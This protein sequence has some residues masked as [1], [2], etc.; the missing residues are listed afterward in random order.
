MNSVLSAKKQS[1]PELNTCNCCKGLDVKAP[2]LINNRPGLY[3]LNYRI[4]THSQFK[5]S[6]LARISCSRDSRLQAAL[7]QLK[8]REDNDFSIALLDAWAV[9]ADVLTFYQERIANESYLLTARERFS[10]LHLARL[11]GYE[12]RP[13]S[14]ASTYL[15]FTMEEPKVFGNQ[16]VPGI[17]ESITLEPG[18]KVQSVPG[19]GES[20][21]T[22][23]TIEKI[24]CRGKWNNIRPRLTKKQQLTSTT[25]TVFLDGIG[26]NLKLG[27]GVLFRADSGTAKGSYV[28]GLVA[29]LEIKAEQNYTEVLLKLKKVESKILGLQD[30]DL[31]GIKAKQNT[32][33]PLVT[34]LL[35]RTIS[36]SELEAEAA[37]EKFKVQETFDNL[38]ASP[39]SSPKVL[40]FRTRAMVF[41]HNAPSWDTL[42]VTLRGD[43]PVYYTTKDGIVYIKDTNP[44][45]YKGREDSWSDANLWEY[46][47]PPEKAEKIVSLKPYNGSAN[48][49]LVNTSSAEKLVNLKPSGK[50]FQIKKIFIKPLYLYNTLY[51]D[52]IYTGVVQGSYVILK[53]EDTWGIYKVEDLTELSV[54]DFTFSTKV[55][56]LT[57][58]NSENYFPKFSIRTT[59][60]FGQ[61]EE[62]SLSRVPEEESFPGEGDFQNGNEC[63]KLEGWINGLY[64]GQHIVVSG[65][66]YGSSGIKAFE[67]AIIDKVEHVLAQDGCTQISLK[68]KL[69]NKYVRSTV[70]INGNVALATHGETREEVLGSGSAQPYQHF[71]LKQPPLTYLTADTPS[72][73][74]ST[75]EVRVNDVLWHEKPKLYGHGPEERIYETHL[76]NEGKT[77]IQFGDGKTGSLLPTG[78]EN[79]RATYR[80]G[81]GLEGLLKANQLSLLMTR[82][83]G[84]SSVT[85]PF[86]SGGGG[87][88]DSEKED[89][90]RQNAPLTVL[91]LDRIVSL[92]DYED[93]ARSFTGISKT[94][95][96][97]AWEGHRRK[98]FITVAGPNGAEIKSDSPIID[99][100]KSAISKAGDPQTPVKVESYKKV[101]FKIAAHINVV[102]DY[103]PDKVL[104]I[105]TDTLRDTFSFSRRSFGQPV[106]LSEVTATIQNVTGVHSVNVLNLYRSDSSSCNPLMTVP[107]SALEASMPIKGS[108]AV[109]AELLILDPGPLTELEVE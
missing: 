75:L 100:L 39:E 63:L 76:D 68:Q 89:E 60:V 21:Q 90:G 4:G 36:S 87:A 86:D 72:G 19:P 82:P 6:M 44:G 10:L 93:F 12:L 5:Q 48:L 26:T 85:N 62:L 49:R 31:Q 27:D 54:S 98:I 96:T 102:P 77:T 35:G 14:A 17:P 55:T 32:L 71:T 107:P 91:T 8:T 16:V 18:I 33:S 66:I 104:R 64:S 67:H 105:V 59:T 74:E 46:N 34:G 53:S 92:K 52:N 20:V 24:E 47:Y 50:D 95:A 70:S 99:K 25:D 30:L 97:W 28:F 94:L 84:L 83:L 23:E 81:L 108:G 38:V 9:I 65:E 88:A 103:T 3:A 58:T 43:E 57:L 61:S 109:A 11:I 101:Y 41:G 56:R 106:L 45:P 15:A 7:N 78:Q 2:V 51:L 79:I 29:K 37:A 13:G 80:R 42:P 40:V 73:V 69:E 1:S 22:F